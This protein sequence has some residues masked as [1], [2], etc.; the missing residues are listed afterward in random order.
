MPRVCTICANPKRRAIEADVVSGTPQR[1]IAGR[2]GIARTSLRRH[3]EGCVR[4]AMQSLEVKYEQ[5]TAVDIHTEMARC[6]GRVNKLFDAC[7]DWLTDPDDP[8]R[9]T[10]DP[11]SEDITVIYEQSNGNGKPA[12]KRESL[13]VL[14]S[15]IEDKQ[16]GLSW[17]RVEIRRADPR[18]LLLKAVDRMRDQMD[19]FGKMTGAFKPNTDEEKPSVPPN[20]VIIIAQRVE[21]AVQELMGRYGLDREAALAIY[22]RVAPEQ[23]KFL[24]GNTH[25][26]RELPLKAVDRQG[27]LRESIGHGNGQ[28][29]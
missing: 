19:M 16:P 17:E 5:R 13:R 27:D 15:R 6:V 11:R 12:R 2:Y 8:T 14:L 26:P 22:E 3:L 20:R 7:A 28:P 29:R 9:Y 23:V 25:D 1:A 4:E 10:L 24:N 18:E 21:I